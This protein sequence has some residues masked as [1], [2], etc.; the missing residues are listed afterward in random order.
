MKTVPC[1]QDLNGEKNVPVLDTEIVHSEGVKVVVENATR[2]NLYI[3]RKTILRDSLNNSE[4]ENLISSNKNKL[5]NNLH[6]SKIDKHK[7]TPGTYLQKVLFSS[8]PN[9]F[10]SQSL[11]NSLE[12]KIKYK[13]VSSDKIEDINEISVP[14]F[15]NDSLN[16]PLTGCWFKTWPERTVDKLTT[17]NACNSEEPA[18]SNSMYNCSSKYSKVEKPFLICK[19]LNIGLNKTTGNKY[20]IVCPA[21]NNESKTS[22]L[23]RKDLP[24]EHCNG[25]AYED[26][27]SIPLDQLLENFPLAYSPVTR[28]LHLIS[29]SKNSS[30]CKLDNFRGPSAIG[31]DVR[32][33]DEVI[34]NQEERS[35]CCKPISQN[36][37]PHSV[38]GL[39]CDEGL[40][41][42]S[43]QYVSVEVSSFS[44]TVSSLSDNSPS[45]NED[46]ALGSLLDCGDTCSLVSLGSCSAFSEDSIGEK[47]RKKSLTGFFSR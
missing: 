22:L 10:R 4:S 40:T 6:H 17:T 21:E 41:F 7:L 2:A 20:D 39:E 36:A 45:T 3:S 27:K 33:N 13:S 25:A 32:T 5:S 14:L 23:P 26:N 38:G 11:P 34:V 19:N 24:S 47:S 16:N 29:N 46:S 37:L 30:N 12:N 43:V 28:Q 15:K 1:K 8:V 35:L 18:S 44:S 42:K 31:T 9:K